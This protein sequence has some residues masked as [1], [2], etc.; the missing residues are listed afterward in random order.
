MC[1]IS[2]FIFQVSFSQNKAPMLQKESIVVPVD[3]APSPKV[4]NDHPVAL[5]SLAMK[6]FERIV[7]RSLMAMT[8]SITDPLQFTYQAKKGVEDAT[9]TLLD[10]VAWA[11][12]G[13]EDACTL[14]DFY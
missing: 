10:F 6:G 4:W 5:T 3:K 12:G 13:Q 11:P 2:K 8:Q 7:K 14:I 1:G 9:A